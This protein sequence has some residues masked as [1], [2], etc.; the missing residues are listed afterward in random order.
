MI[1]RNWIIHPERGTKRNIIITE[2][3]AIQNAKEQEQEGIE[4]TLCWYNHRTKQAETPPGWLIWS[5]WE[6]GAGIC[7][8]RSDGKYI[9]L[10]GWQADFCTA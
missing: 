4:P 7:Y 10:S 3:E 5:T 2:S 6:D 1:E 8:K 9:V